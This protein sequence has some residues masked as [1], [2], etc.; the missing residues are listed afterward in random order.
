VI[1]AVELFLNLRLKYLRGIGER[2]LVRD[3]R[4]GRE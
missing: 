1:I 3:R 4:K 2:G